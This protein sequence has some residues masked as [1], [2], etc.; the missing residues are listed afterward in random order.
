MKKSLNENIS[1][2]EQY[3]IDNVIDTYKH[4]KSGKMALSGK[5]EYNMYK[6]IADKTGFLIM[7]S[8]FGSLSVGMSEQGIKHYNLK[9]KTESI[10]EMI[11][12][13]VKEET[14]N[15]SDKAKKLYQ[16]IEFLESFPLKSN[17]YEDQSDIVKEL[18]DAKLCVIDTKHRN[19][20]LAK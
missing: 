20:I 4:T 16:N 9:N 12:R 6:K 8:G 15:L 10:Q 19:L 5:K 7:Y 2:Q 1:K 17:K 3:L 14:T 18:I 11:R 13:I